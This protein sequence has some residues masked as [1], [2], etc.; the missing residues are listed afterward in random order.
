M[1]LRSHTTPH[2]AHTAELSRSDLVQS[3]ARGSRAQERIPMEHRKLELAFPWHWH[4][5]Q[6][7]WEDINKESRDHAQG[8]TFGL[9][10]F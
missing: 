8:G 9:P 1:E 10:F 3:E 4:Y 7:R 5:V 6:L 2:T